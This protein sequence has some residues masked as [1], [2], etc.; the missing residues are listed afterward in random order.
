M[1]VGGCFRNEGECEPVAANN[2]ENGHDYGIRAMTVI[3]FNVTTERAVETEQFTAQAW[4]L[5]LG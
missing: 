3:V 5:G 1:N 2:H 4:Q